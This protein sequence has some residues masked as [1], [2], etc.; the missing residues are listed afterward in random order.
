MT[1]LLFVIGALAACL[2]GC[3]SPAGDAGKP[4]TGSTASF[5]G[6][7]VR[8][9]NLSDG[10]AEAFLNGQTYGK[11]LES[12]GAS[13]FKLTAFKNPAKVG[14]SSASG[15]HEFTVPLKGG[16]AFTVVFQGTD[17]PTVI[18]GEPTEIAGGRSVVYFHSL[19]E[20][21]TGHKVAVKPG[22]GN[23][24]ELA[25]A[26]RKEMSPGSYEA[27]VQLAGGKKA[28]V[29]FDVAGG[30]AITLLL[31]GTSSEPKLIVL[32]NNTQMIVTGFGGASPTG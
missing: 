17:K 19:L 26:E 16:T 27:T 20:G 5:K 24:V 18:E 23:G 7:K 9:L 6:A 2:L 10:S 12:E 21:G 1:R 11:R 32:V 8:V 4:V 31:K 14:V 22:Q 15:S 13:S 25:Y 30:D 28:S 29:T 3:N